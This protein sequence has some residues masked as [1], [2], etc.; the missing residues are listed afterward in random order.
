MIHVFSKIHLLAEADGGFQKAQ[1]RLFC[2]FVSLFAVF[3]LVWCFVLF[4][5]WCFALLGGGAVICVWLWSRARVMLPQS[6]HFCGLT[7]H[8]DQPHLVSE[9]SSSTIF[10]LRK[11]PRA[12]F[13][14]GSEVVCNSLFC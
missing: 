5:P 10:A 4:E 9:V 3:F 14:C 1:S 11:Y 7:L 2:C 6:L 8:P 12:C 13:P